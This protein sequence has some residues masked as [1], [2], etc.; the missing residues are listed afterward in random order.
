MPEAVACFRFYWIRLY[1]FMAAV[2]EV[3]EAVERKVLQLAF[4]AGRSN[5]WKVS[6]TKR[7]LLIINSNHEIGQVLIYIL[8]YTMS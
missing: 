5:L 1:G 7:L 2:G 8:E 3:A 6:A 4:Q